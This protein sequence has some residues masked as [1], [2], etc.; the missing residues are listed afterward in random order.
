MFRHRDLAVVLAAASTLI[1]W[2][3]AAAQPPQE[4]LGR[5]CA[6][7]PD[8]PHCATTVRFVAPTP[9]EGAHVTAPFALDVRVRGVAPVGVVRYFFLDAAGGLSSATRERE[10]GTRFVVDGELAQRLAS[11]SPVA[12]QACAYAVDAPDLGLLACS[13]LRTLVVDG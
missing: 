6:R 12:V 4:V 5:I 7:A 3:A 13:D 9:G 11:T 8:H 1:P 10:L 2:T